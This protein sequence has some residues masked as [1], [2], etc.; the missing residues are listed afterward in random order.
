MQNINT[1]RIGG[2]PCAESAIFGHGWWYFRSL[3]QSLLDIFM[4]RVKE[5]LQRLVFDGVE[6]PH[7]KSPSL[8]R[9][10][11]AEEHD[12]DHIDKLDF[13]AHH[14]SDTG[15]ESGQLRQ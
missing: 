12:L 11:L 15:L 6:L 7:I 8:T 9:E 5:L 10:D 13:L 14:V 3:E 1:Y 4:R 2:A